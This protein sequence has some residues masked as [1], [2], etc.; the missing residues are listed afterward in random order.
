MSIGDREKTRALL[1]ECDVHAKRIRYAQEQCAPFF[2]L[3]A[4][5]YKT[6]TEDAITY[7]D[8]LVYRYT[9]LQ[10]TLGAKLFPLIVEHLREDAESLTIVDKLSQLERSGAIESSQKWQEMREL[11][12][13]LAHDYEDDPDSAADYLNEL[14]TSSNE[15]LSFQ[16]RASRFVHERILPTQ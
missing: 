11:R 3:T 16:T 8:Q 14:F 1:H 7:L 10:D 5:S 9:K 12:N 13:Q 2:P 15:L 6:L 4:T